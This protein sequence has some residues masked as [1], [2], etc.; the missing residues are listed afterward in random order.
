MPTDQDKTIRKLRAI[1]SKVL[2]VKNEDLSDDKK[3]EFRI[4][5]NIGDIV[6]DGNR[7]YGNG[8]KCS[9]PYRRSC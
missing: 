7:I 3:L 8:V 2:K 5:V 4:G 6:Q 9:C 1:L